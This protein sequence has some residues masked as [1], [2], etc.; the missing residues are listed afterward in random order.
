MMKQEN[1]FIDLKSEPITI[2]ERDP[3]LMPNPPNDDEKESN[4]AEQQPDFDTIN[5]LI[6]IDGIKN[7]IVSKTSV[8]FFKLNKFNHSI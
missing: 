4:A 6:P 7:E 5:E 2:I 8:E 3:L 1:E